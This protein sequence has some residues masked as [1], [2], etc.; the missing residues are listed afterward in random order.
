VSVLRRA[1]GI[2]SNFRAS[3]ASATL[4]AANAAVGGVT[5]ALASSGSR[6]FATKSGGV[7]GPRAIDCPSF[8]RSIR[9]KLP[10]CQI[11]LAAL[12]RTAPYLFPV[13]ELYERDSFIQQTASVAGYNSVLADIRDRTRDMEVAMSLFAECKAAG[14]NPDVKMFNT[15]MHIAGMNGR[16][17]IVLRLYHELDA[18]DLRP[19]VESTVAVIRGLALTDFAKAEALLRKMRTQVVPPAAAY[20]FLMRAALHRRD[21][22]KVLELCKEMSTHK[23]PMSQYTYGC[24]LQACLVMLSDNTSSDVL[25]VLMDL[26]QKGLQP[27]VFVYNKLILFFVRS[28]KP[29]KGLEIMRRMR[30]QGVQMQRFT[31]N[32]LISGFCEHGLIAQALDIFQ[33]LEND[34]SEDNFPV[35]A[36]YLPILDFY[37]QNNDQLQL[38][39]WMRKMEQSSVEF[40]MDCFGAVVGHRVRMQDIGGAV[41][42]TAKMIERGY[43]AKDVYP[44]LLR[45]FVDSSNLRHAH[46]L[47]MDKLQMLGVTPTVHDFTMLLE[48]Y[49][50]HGRLKQALG[51]FESMRQLK[52]Q[53]NAWTFNSL[54]KAC[55]DAGDVEQMWKV[56]DEMQALGL[57]ASAYTYNLLMCGL[58]NANQ[59]DTAR[60]LL[61]DMQAA[62]FHPDV[63]TY[64]ILLNGL[65]RNGLVSEAHMLFKSMQASGITPSLQSYCSLLNCYARSDDLEGATRILQELEASD[66]RLNAFVY[67]PIIHCHVK[68]GRLAEAY[69]VFQNMVRRDIIPSAVTYCSMIPAFAADPMMHDVVLQLWDRLRRAKYYA[70]HGAFQAVLQVMLARSAY[71][72]AF[73]HIDTMFHLRFEPNITP[74]SM[75]AVVAAVPESVLLSARSEPLRTLATSSRVFRQANKLHV[76]IRVGDRAD[77]KHIVSI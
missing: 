18:L 17:D 22:Q 43:E 9:S 70:T 12:Q 49:A 4:S 76:A 50:R 58:V 33:Q 68:R 40:D 15:L 71:E 72:Q 75:Q 10:V 6:S 31:Y 13:H 44:H 21:A 59:M 28:G 53:P 1:A 67:T 62:G 14:L 61:Q 30:E 35:A 38:K 51:V 69:A 42:L 73:T 19:N 8:W 66:L 11:K 36:S 25:E 56:L 65:G 24:M 32:V 48:G 52:L 27:G 37:S 39:K 3:V 74:E 29:L 5:A 16:S 45:A 2:M 46:S 47:V 20:G 64:T 57:E 34:P 63:Y 23:I 26:E 77:P 41:D 7:K 60:I 54:L 55:R